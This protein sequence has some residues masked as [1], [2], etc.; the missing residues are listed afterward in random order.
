M[1]PN[2]WH[3]SCYKTT[4]QGMLGF[5]VLQQLESHRLGNMATDGPMYH[6]SLQG[7]IKIIAHTAPC[8]QRP[9]Y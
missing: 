1:F 8:R 7:Q 6:S 9:Q 4:T 2:P 5:V 3:P